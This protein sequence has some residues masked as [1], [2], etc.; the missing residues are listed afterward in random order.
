MMTHYLYRSL[1]ASILITTLVGC[2]RSD[3]PTQFDF[4][5]ISTP[6]NFLKY[7]NPYPSLPAGDYTL[8]AATANTGVSNNFV[9]NILYDDGSKQTYTGNWSN[10]GGQD[11]SSVENR[12]FTITLDKAGGLTASLQ[13]TADNYLYLLDSSDNILFENDNDGGGTNATISLPKSRIDNTAWSAAYY[14]A[15]DPLNKRTTLAAWKKKNGFDG[16]DIHIIFRDTKDLGY[17]RDMHARR[18]ANGCMAIYVRNFAVNIIDGLP[19]NTLNLTAA[20]ANDS[21]HHFGTNAIEFSDLDGNCDGADPLF[22]KFYTFKAYPDNPAADE[23][24]L[25]KVDLDHRGDKAMPLP[26]IVCHGGSAYPLLSDGTFPSAALP[27]TANPQLRVGDVNARLQP[28]EVD[29]FEFSTVSGY[30][31]AEQEIKLHQFNQMIYAS[32]P[33]VAPADG[34]WTG[35][36]IK[37]VTN[38]W[39]N[40][41]ITN[42]NN[43]T[44]APFVP[45]GWTYDPGDNDPPLA[46]EELF[47]K[48]VKPYCFSCHSKRG[49]NRGTNL[50]ASNNGKDID[51]S[52]YSKFISYAEKIDDYVYV[53]GLMPLSRLTYTKFW[54]SDAPEI[55]ATHIPGFSHG[56]ADGSINQPGAPIANPGLNRTTNT[57]VTLSA[58]SSLFAN[59][60]TWSILSPTPGSSNPALSSTTSIRP[61]F[62]TD[63]DGEYTL[64]LI[65][66]NG[67]EQSAPAT[68]TLTVNNSLTPAVN[69]ITFND[70]K[71]VLQDNTT[72]PI[73]ATS[74]DCMGC[75]VKA[76][77]SAPA[78]PI[79]GI[80]LYYSDADQTPG[81]SLYQQVLRR[82]NFDK[83]E[84]SPLL[85]KPSGNHHYGG[86]RTG[87]DLAGDH[88]KYDLFLNWILQG[89]REN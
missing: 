61:I 74:P 13:S 78:T 44:F 52:T 38:G 76:G 35:D 28:L 27:D 4:T 22:A 83:P 34:E 62:S 26:C 43:T 39:Y 51:F 12:R 41:D 10:S 7:P 80:P 50:N 66:S 36:F 88:S 18:N 24:R 71:A 54:E 47:L 70:I 84:L 53:R 49:S 31:R 23:T 82:V 8:V 75:H 48:V 37:E 64:Q 46:A 67:A 45:A 58:A 85:L 32:F 59:Q 19:Y 16:G 68:L 6:D 55:L 79:A 42:G 1:L 65:V 89:A 73:P 86:L 87:F 21:K 33:Q 20:V 56:N 25:D 15:I 60:Y 72:P 69:V 30:S 11:K 57:P 77:A 2:N 29:S 81:I 40:N 63:V 9:L 3:T 5:S 14:K 17:G